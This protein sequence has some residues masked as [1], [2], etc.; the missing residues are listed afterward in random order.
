MK[1][2][3]I[4]RIKTIISDKRALILGLIRAIEKLVC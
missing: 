1:A 3:I 2:Y 4:V